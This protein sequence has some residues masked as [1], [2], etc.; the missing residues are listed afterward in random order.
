[1]TSL[2]WILDDGI[3]RCGG[4]FSWNEL[5]TIISSPEFSRP[6]LKIKFNISNFHS[7]LTIE[8]VT[9]ISL[10]RL[11]AAYKNKTYQTVFFFIGIFAVRQYRR[12]KQRSVSKAVTVAATIR[13][14]TDPTIGPITSAKFPDWDSLTVAVVQLLFICISKK[15][16]EINKHAACMLICIIQPNLH[17]LWYYYD[18]KFQPSALLLILNCGECESIYVVEMLVRS[19]HWALN[20]PWRISL[21]HSMISCQCFNMEH[22]F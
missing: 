8:I 21:Y 18:G 14:T 3:I 10:P 22:K 19:A 11:T 5:L 13:N 6:M 15:F 1:M 2:S 12:Y 20:C 9:I 4:R 17:D 16:E 7:T